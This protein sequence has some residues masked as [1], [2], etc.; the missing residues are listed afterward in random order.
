MVDDPQQYRVAWGLEPAQWRPV[1]RLAG[2]R[3]RAVF[4]WRLDGAAP[5]DDVALRARRAYDRLGELGVSVAADATPERIEVT[6]PLARVEMALR[7]LAEWAILPDAVAV[8]D[9]PADQLRALRRDV[10]G[11]R[12]RVAL[13]IGDYHE[14]DPV[15]ELRAR[16][17]LRG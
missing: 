1:G 2:V 7:T 5:A 15:A 17:H 16:A 9:V 14:S 12:G 13:E 8:N 4:A 11:W 3:E 6:L 10:A